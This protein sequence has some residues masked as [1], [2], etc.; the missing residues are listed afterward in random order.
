MR[1]GLSTAHISGLTVFGS[2]RAVA[3]A[4]VSAHDNKE[5]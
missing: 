1:S 4:A 2:T 5:R 3:G